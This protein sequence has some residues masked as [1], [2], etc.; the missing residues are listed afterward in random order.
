ML[1]LI[2]SEPKKTIEEAFNNACKKNGLDVKKRKKIRKSMK[3]I[4]ENDNIYI[5]SHDLSIK[6]QSE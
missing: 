4:D 2:K 5:I 3:V 6:K 1:V